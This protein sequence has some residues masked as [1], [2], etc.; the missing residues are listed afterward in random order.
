M[1]T[2]GQRWP[3][4]SAKR[5]AKIYL[6]RK[7]RDV[8]WPKRN[9]ASHEEIRGARKTKDP[10]LFYPYAFGRGESAGPL[11][12]YKFLWDDMAAPSVE[13]E[14]SRSHHIAWDR[15]NASNRQE[16]HEES[17]IARREPSCD[18]SVLPQFTAIN[19]VQK[20]CTEPLTSQVSSQLQ[21]T[22]QASLSATASAITIVDLTQEDKI[23]ILDIVEPAASTPR[24]SNERGTSLSEL[25]QTSTWSS[26]L[27]EVPSDEESTPSEVSEQ[28][29]ARSM[30][31]K[32]APVFTQL[33]TRRSKS[34]N[35]FEAQPFLTD[36]PV[37]TFSFI[38]QRSMP[39]R[40]A[41]QYAADIEASQ[42]TDQ[43]VI[44]AVTAQALEILSSPTQDALETTIT[45]TRQLNQCRKTAP[46]FTLQK[47]DGAKRARDNLGQN[48]PTD[49][50]TRTESSRSELQA[51]LGKDLRQRVR[52][53]ESRKK[54][55]WSNTPRIETTTDIILG[56]ILV[57][58]SCTT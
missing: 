31:S 48:D 44:D 32:T 17:A 53:R 38:R 10:S 43:A 24:I 30:R 21:P 14:D 1:K 37:N 4:L 8:A 13:I 6:D 22:N 34:N 15:K 49:D 39:E 9:R 26:K 40:D 35:R 16:G 36:T 19:K 27:N 50:V 47:L 51:P 2:L 54:V 42:P 52:N 3:T 33:K 25:P 45:E 41:S 11:P 46:E 56:Q 28:F 12:E 18:Y 23:S 29:L 58:F 57:Q 55:E 5:R 7:I 20:P